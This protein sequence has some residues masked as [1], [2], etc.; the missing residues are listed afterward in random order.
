MVSLSAMFRTQYNI[1]FGVIFDF[2]FHISA[3]KYRAGVKFVNVSYLHAAL[4]LHR[5]T[6]VD[7]QRVH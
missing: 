1:D 7:A 6:T 4:R 5:Y 3:Y 2:I